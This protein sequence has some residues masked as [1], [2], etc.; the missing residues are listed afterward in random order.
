MGRPQKE[1]EPEDLP[2]SM[3]INNSFGKKAGEIH[4]VY[5]TILSKAHILFKEMRR[6]FVILALLAS[7]AGVFAQHESISDTIMLHEVTTFAP[8]KKYQAGAKIESIPANQITIGQSGSVDQLLMRFTPVYLKSTGSGLSTVHFR[9]TSAS[10]TSVNFG[11]ININSL[12]LGNSNMAE[13]PVFLFDNI[14]LQFGSSSA[15]NGSGSIGG[16]IY[17]GLANEWT[18]GIKLKTTISEGSFGEQLY[19]ARL[20]AGNG[21]FESVTRL[22]YLSLK[23]NFPF[24]NPKLGDRENPGTFRDRQ[25]GAAIENTGVIQEINY[26][27][28][29]K[30]TLK[31]AA[32]LEHDWHEVQ[33]TTKENN[34]SK[35]PE[36]LDNKNIR[37]W[38]EYENLKNP[39][40]LKTGLGFVH[41]MQVY[42]GNQHQKIGTNRLISEVEGK[43]DIRLNFGY[44]LGIKYQYIKPDVYAYSADVIKYE[45]QADLYFSAFYTAWNRLKTTINLRQQFVTNFSAPFTPSVGAEYTLF[46]N[47]ISV[48]KLNGNIAR[49]YRIP[50]FNDRYWGTQGNANLKPED[51]M[52]YELGIVHQLCTEKFQ[53]EIKLN[54]FYMDVKNWIEWRLGAVDWIAQNV[55][56]VESKGIEFQSNTDW[57]VNQI[58]FNFR[59]NYSFNPVESLKDESPTGVT[60]RQLLYIPKH[61]GNAYL[62]LNYK[63]WNLFVDGNY[64]GKR[65]ADYSGTYAMPLGYELDPYLLTNCGISRKLSLAKQQFFLS[66]ALNNILNT[67]YQNERFY[68]MPGRS[69]RI[70]LS[71]NLNIH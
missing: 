7:A 35:Q 51:G 1:G 68:G 2:V 48:L 57:K 59:L 70:S 8:L 33:L 10:H 20:F 31:S 45:Q 58:Q 41:D 13:I 21:R 63:S 38:S 43:Q 39:L 32:W 66:F 19:G 65:F 60:G 14:D 37:F 11:G 50:T 69:F 49:S 4:H 67:D 46:T 18:N 27:F 53:S 29:E 22:F 47:D 25:R 62:M 16:A 9:G 52:N 42:D 34:T 12:S 30:E 28:G 6:F 71:T 3:S 40:N 36:T 44:K 55:M 5:F 64:T 56:E 24:N 23:N 26:R 15:V 54:A 61:I 17:L